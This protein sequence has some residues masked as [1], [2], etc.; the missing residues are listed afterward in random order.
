MVDF[1]TNDVALPILIVTRPSAKRVCGECNILSDP[2]SAGKLATSVE[3]SCYSEV[4]IVDAKYVLLH[5]H[6]IWSTGIS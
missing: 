6:N 5:I 4:R 2:V 3:K 1:G